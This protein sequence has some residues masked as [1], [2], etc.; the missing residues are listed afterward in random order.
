[1]FDEA[2]KIL[3]DVKNNGRNSVKQAIDSLKL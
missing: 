3:Y 2:D 1:M